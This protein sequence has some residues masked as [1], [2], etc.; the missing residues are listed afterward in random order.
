MRISG[1]GLAQN[2]DISLGDGWNRLRGSA[3]EGGAAALS[4]THTRQKSATSRLS[5]QMYRFKTSKL[6]NSWEG[7]PLRGCWM[8]LNN[9]SY[10]LF[11]GRIRSQVVRSPW[12]RASFK[13]PPSFPPF[14]GEDPSKPWARSNR[15]ISARHGGMSS[16]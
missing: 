13:W 12:A 7:K 15:A 8:K 4:S 14:C 5:S 6:L 10:P 11:Y 16:T 2:D 1:D 9:G 3:L